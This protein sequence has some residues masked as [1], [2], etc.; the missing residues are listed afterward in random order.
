MTLHARAAVCLRTALAVRILSRMQQ[1]TSKQHATCHYHKSVV[2]GTN[3]FHCTVQS[4]ALA[5]L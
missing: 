4:A 5:G 1:N 3:M 2:V